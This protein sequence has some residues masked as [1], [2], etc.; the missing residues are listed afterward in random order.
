MFEYAQDSFQINCHE[1]FVMD[2]WAQAAF[3][4]DSNSKS[5]LLTGCFSIQLFHFTSM[6]DFSNSNFKVL[7]FWKEWIINSNMV[8]LPCII[9]LFLWTICASENS[10]LLFHSILHAKV[11]HNSMSNA[12]VIAGKT[13]APT[14]CN[15]S[16]LP[17]K[18]FFC[19]KILAFAHG[20]TTTTKF[21]V[22]VKCWSQTML[23]PSF[24]ALLPP[25]LSL[26]QSPGALPLHPHMCPSEGCTGTAWDWDS[27][28]CPG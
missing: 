24:A 20:K 9:H 28:L 22:V 11:P 7:H 23:I 10:L 17:S 27:P 3:R 21:I 8:K 26:V 5:F 12:L 19:W 18:T 4:Q 25:L 2:L 15:I 14:Y 16:K 6:L 1:V 13:R